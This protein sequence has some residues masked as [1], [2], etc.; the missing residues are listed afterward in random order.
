MKPHIKIGLLFLT[1]ML[2]GTTLSA[3]SFR[4]LLRKANQ[5][6][7]LKAF[8]KAIETYQQALDRRPE[9]PKALGNMADCFRHINQMEEAAEH[10]AQALKDRKSDNRYLFEYAMVLKALGRYDEAKQFFQRYAQQQDQKL[11]AHYAQSCDFA[12]L[13]RG[14]AT[15]FGITNE[16]VN[17]I[18]A[19]FGPAFFLDQVVFS[20][21]RTDVQRSTYDWDGT[22]KN[23]LYKSAVSASGDL[24]PPV[25]LRGVAN[26]RGQ[27]PAS[28]S[29]DGRYVAYVRNNYVS[30]TR[31][32]P[33]A[34]MELSIF[35]AEMNQDGNW[36]NERPFPHNDEQNRTGYPCFTPD[37]NALF[38]ASDRPGGFGG[39]DIY[40]SYRDGEQWT[41]PIN[42]GPVINTQGNELSPFFDGTDLYF[43]SDW[44]YGFGGLDIFKAEQGDGEWR[45]VSNVGQPI[46]SPYDDFD[47][48]FDNFENR[49]Y[50]TSNR[51][52]GRGAEDIYRVS[53]GG[54]RMQLS[55]ADA[56]DGGPVSN[57]TIDLS[58][59]RRVN[60]SDAIINADPR[61]NYTLPINAELDCDAVISAPN[62]NTKRVELS[63]LG[64]S[65]GGSVA[66]DLVKRGE[67]YPGRVING[68]TRLPVEEVTIR[69]RN[70]NSSHVSEA[71]TNR[72]GDYVLALES[73]T[74]YQ[75][76]Y[77]APQF[78]D[79][80][81][82]VS[83][84][85]GSDRDL[86]NTLLAP[87]DQPIQE[88]EPPQQEE[89]GEEEVIRSGYAVQL[90]AMQ[91]APDL[92]RYRSLRSIGKVYTVQEGNMYK[93]RVGVYASRSEAA[94]S[95]R[96]IRNN[97]YPDAWVVQE[98][99]AASSGGP[100]QPEP[101]NNTTYSNYLIQLIALRNTSNFDA[102]PLQSYGRV[103]ERSRQGL[104]VKLLSGF[105]NLQ[106]ARQ[107]LGQV[108]RM[109]YPNAYIVEE[110]NGQLRPVSR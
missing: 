19:D 88:D 67:G 26:D 23:Q 96:Q 51:P 81:R 58:N 84:A 106:E 48:V 82:S 25:F 86:G 16:R 57:A 7:E 49:G 101:N 37:G 97:G 73:N 104:T 21:A 5:Q 75:I 22:A 71:S 110:V 69:A 98:A 100:S 102:G 89:E 74:N 93:V 35:L 107:T 63:N 44:H 41:T 13:Q 17:S 92:E 78:R 105:R 18:A 27:G 14:M 34:G 72:S 94:S 2:L 3:Q 70:A 87:F 64:L 56:A 6:Y 24:Q 38:F 54:D 42:L 109:G 4:S 53:M 20:S 90:A 62:Y 36:Y 50:F 108:K 1:T 79:T 46:N 39:Y 59:C 9:D 76:T 65:S 91:K 99:G 77:S 85:N 33:S 55:I 10:Y 80:R 40:I 95:K 61:G 29:A 103:V 30:G 52:S 83:T 60:S 32:I 11:G 66:I 15:D 31:H 43:A 12:K 47:M 8:N 28:F 68:V 45:K